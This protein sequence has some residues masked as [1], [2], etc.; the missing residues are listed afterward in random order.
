MDKIYFSA[1]DIAEMLDVSKAKA[2][3]IIKSLNQRLEEQGYL[4]I[5]GK[6][7]RVYFC[8]QWYGLSATCEG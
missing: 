1:E 4:T 7:S 3:N 5:S 6:I 8:E 2:Y